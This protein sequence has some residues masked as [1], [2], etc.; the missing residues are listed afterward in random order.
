[1][2]SLL[3]PSLAVKLAATAALVVFAT[4]IAEK[5][6]A[7]IGAMI[8]AL[9]LSADLHTFFISME[10]D[11]AFVAQSALTGLG[12]NAMISPFL[13]VSAM[14]IH[15]F[16]IWVGLGVGFVFWTSGSLAILH[17]DLPFLAAI[18]LNLAAFPVSLYLSH[19]YLDVRRTRATKGGLLDVALRTTAVVAVAA[20]VIITGRLIGPEM[21]GFVAVIP[22]VLAQHVGGL[23]RKGRTAHDSVRV[24]QRR[25]GD[26]WLLPRFDG[27]TLDD[28]PERRDGG[29]SCGLVH[30]CL[31]ELRSHHRP[32]LYTVLS[33]A[34]FYI[35]SGCVFFGKCAD[36]AL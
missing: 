23:V 16:G 19:P 34:W 20:A 30:L 29:P 9:P 21:A 28:G 11:A 26:V 7:F 27:L 32:A 13:V 15:R 24:G 31:L 10:H 22:I 2:E 6:G 25:C 5:V 8:A 1:M 17:A 12:I 36:D 33:S 35:A 3:D 4:L 14:L 18:V